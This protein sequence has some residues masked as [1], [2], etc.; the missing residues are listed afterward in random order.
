M[1][2]WKKERKEGGGAYVEVR[3]VVV[4]GRKGILDPHSGWTVFVV[5]FLTHTSGELRRTE[6]EET[7]LLV[8]LGNKGVSLFVYVREG[9]LP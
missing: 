1:G 8:V 6:E 3:G 7:G 4:V 5:S 9:R 2:E